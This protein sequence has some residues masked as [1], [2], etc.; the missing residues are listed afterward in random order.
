M[1]DGLISKF[2]RIGKTN[3]TKLNNQLNV[4]QDKISNL[5]SKNLGN[6]KAVKVNTDD[7]SGDS[8]SLNVDD[9]LSTIETA[10]KR[11]Q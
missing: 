7:L 4:I 3:F 10:K 11:A 9:F 8:S 5:S 2:Q 6:I 1:T